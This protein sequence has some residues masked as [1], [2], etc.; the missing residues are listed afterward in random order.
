VPYIT[1]LQRG[2]F[3]PHICSLARDIKTP[4]DANYV[5]TVLLQ[6]A[7]DLTHYSDYNAVIGILECAKLEFYR[8]AV[9]PYEDE[10]IKENGDVY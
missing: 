6:E 4:G 2:V 5:I 1:K 8:R 3:N 9:A 7:F 10:K